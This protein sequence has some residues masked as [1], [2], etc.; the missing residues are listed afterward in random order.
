MDLLYD[1]IGKGYT[2]MRREDPRIAARLGD[3]RAEPVPVPHDCRDGF[4]HA[5]WRRPEAYLSDAVRAGISVFARMDDATVKEGV[6]RLRRDLHSGEWRRRN[7]WL[8]ELDELDAGY[9]LVLH[10][11]TDDPA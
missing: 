6:E 9:R 5:Y 1:S 11:S 2:A 8:L 10:E 7:A 3:A 4:F